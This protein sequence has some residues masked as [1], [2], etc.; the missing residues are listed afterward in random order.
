MT[1]WG[2]LIPD[3]ARQVLWMTCGSCGHRQQV[4]PSVLPGGGL[5]SYDVGEAKGTIP[6]LNCGY[7]PHLPGPRD[8]A[9]DDGLPD[10]G[11]RE[12]PMHGMARML[13][14]VEANRRREQKRLW[15]IEVEAAAI[16]DQACARWYLEQRLKAGEI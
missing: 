1:R 16:V 5:P 14:A 3:H 11:V 12:E 7:S 6:C 2:M 9:L 15:A 4:A 10:P 13:A 8:R